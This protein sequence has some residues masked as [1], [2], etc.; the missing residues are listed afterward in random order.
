MKKKLCADHRG[1]ALHAAVRIGAGSRDRL[2]RPCRYLTR[3]PFAQDRLSLTDDGDIVDRFCRTLD[4]FG[5]VGICEIS[6]NSLR[7]FSF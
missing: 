3:P 4:W 5:V 7:S 2:E 6:L 1:F